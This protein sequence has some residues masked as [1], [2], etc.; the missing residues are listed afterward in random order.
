[1][2][3]V[4]QSKS[5]ELFERDKLKKILRSLAR[6]SGQHLRTIGFTLSGPAAFSIC[7]YRNCRC[8]WSVKTLISS[9]PLSFFKELLR[10]SLR[11]F[12]LKS[13][14]LKPQKAFSLSVYSSLFS[15][16]S[17][18]HSAHLVPFENKT[19]RTQWKTEK[20]KIKNPSHRHSSNCQ[21]ASVK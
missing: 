21:Y 3:E 5:T 12:V 2:Q 15:N 18:Y 4:F 9:S 17:Y 10:A 11:L 19:C 16:P 14:Q 1:M 8:T 6:W 13:W 20:R 7:T